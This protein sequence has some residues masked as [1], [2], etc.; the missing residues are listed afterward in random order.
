MPMTGCEDD[1][2]LTFMEYTNPM[3]N[4]PVNTIDWLIKAKQEAKQW[5]VIEPSS[6][7]IPINEQNGWRDIIW[8]SYIKWYTYQGEDYYEVRYGMLEMKGGLKF[9]TLNFQCEIYDSQGNVCYRI[10]GGDAGVIEPGYEHFSDFWSIATFKSLL[11]E[12]KSDN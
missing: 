3:A 8:G 6:E 12:Y 10:I 9:G 2:D 4:N 5:F 11:W 7:R 1:D